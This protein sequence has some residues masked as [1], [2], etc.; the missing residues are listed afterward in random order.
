MHS[1]SEVQFALIRLI[2]VARAISAP[3]LKD[4]IPVLFYLGTQLRDDVLLNGVLRGDGSQARL[5]SD[6]LRTC[7]EGRA[8]LVAANTSAMLCFRPMLKNLSRRC[9]SQNACFT[10]LVKMVCDGMEEGVFAHADPLR[11]MTEWVKEG[12]SRWH[13]CGVCVDQLLMNHS[14]AHKAVWEELATVF[15]L[16]P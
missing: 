2:G 16:A 7:I 1:R 6:D 9:T 12:N 8:S 15:H 11:D 10:S 5:H 13:L 14:E 3:E 4:M